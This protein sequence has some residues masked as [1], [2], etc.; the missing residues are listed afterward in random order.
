MS[1]DVPLQM[2]DLAVDVIFAIYTITERENCT[3]QNHNSAHLQFVLY[4]LD[5]DV[6]VFNAVHF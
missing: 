6:S 3:F 2:Q 5:V 1:L 4:F